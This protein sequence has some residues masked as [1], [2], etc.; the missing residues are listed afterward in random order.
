MFPQH[1]KYVVV[2]GEGV[3]KAPCGTLGELPL[4]EPP[5]RKDSITKVPPKLSFGFQDLFFEVF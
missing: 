4:L 2:K 3:P 1:P 5:S